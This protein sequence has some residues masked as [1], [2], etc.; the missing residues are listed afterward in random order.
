MTRARLITRTP[1]A[2]PFEDQRFACSVCGREFKFAPAYGG[3]SKRGAY[4][5][6]M[7]RFAKH[8]KRFHGSIS[9]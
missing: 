7:T 8:C 5:Y 1:I 6:L 4:T 9:L 2:A 3:Y